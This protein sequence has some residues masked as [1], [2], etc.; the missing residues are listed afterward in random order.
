VTTLPHFSSTSNGYLL[1]LN[2]QVVYLQ[3]I[4]P[5]YELNHNYSF[6]TLCDPGDIEYYFRSRIPIF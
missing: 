4:K 1:L 3:A 5:N 2:F 6:G